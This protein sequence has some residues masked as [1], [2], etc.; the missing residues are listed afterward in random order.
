MKLNRTKINYI[1]RKM[2]QGKSGYQVS[3]EMNISY[4]RVYQIYREYLKTGKIPELKQ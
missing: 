4:E 3:E 2:D 1:I